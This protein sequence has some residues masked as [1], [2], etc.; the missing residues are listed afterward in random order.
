[1]PASIR[2][3][4]TCAFAGCKNLTGMYFEGNAPACKPDAFINIG[5]AFVIYYKSGNTG[6]DPRFMG[7]ITAVY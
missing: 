2:L 6:F 5:N 4:D 3:I 7:W 1:M